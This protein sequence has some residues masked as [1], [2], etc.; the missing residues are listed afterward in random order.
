MDVN[1]VEESGPFWEGL[2]D[3]LEADSKAAG[4]CKGEPGVV[5]A[6][7]VETGECGIEEYEV[8][9]MAKEAREK[10]DRLLAQEESKEGT[11]EG[12][13]DSEEEFENEWRASFTTAERGLEV[14]M[15][16]GVAEPVD[17]VVCELVVL[18]ASLATSIIASSCADEL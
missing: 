16:W 15:A 3:M 18:S 2:E 1:S 10:D 9:D 8:C 14:D 11:V 12:E 6:L 4:T 17:M 13:L 5:E 7:E